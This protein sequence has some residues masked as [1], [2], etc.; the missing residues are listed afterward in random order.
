MKGHANDN[1]TIIIFFNFKKKNFQ[2][3]FGQQ[4]VTAKM[5]WYYTTIRHSLYKILECQK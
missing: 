1:K 3:L 2:S 4:E 5:A